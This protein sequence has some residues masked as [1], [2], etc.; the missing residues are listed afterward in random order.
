MV[1]GKLAGL[2]GKHREGSRATGTGRSTRSSPWSAPTNLPSPLLSPL[3][4]SGGDGARPV[5]N[6]NVVI[7]LIGTQAAHTEAWP[8]THSVT[9][10]NCSNPICFD[11]AELSQMKLPGGR[12]VQG[13]EDAAPGGDHGMMPLTQWHPETEPSQHAAWPRPAWRQNPQHCLP[14]CVQGLPL[15]FLKPHIRAGHGAYLDH[16]LPPCPHHVAVHGVPCVQGSGEGRVSQ[17]QVASCN[18]SAKG[19]HRSTQST[20]DQRVLLSIDWLADSGGQPEK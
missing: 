17:F 12:A 7:K 11:N 19:P 1:S 6:P 8:E 2:G 14:C 9:I 4:Q 13:R 5:A 18:I 10:S 3:L 15:A 16:K 20:L